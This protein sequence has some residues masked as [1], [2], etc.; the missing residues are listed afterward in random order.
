M[1][2]AAK[3]TFIVDKITVKGREFYFDGN[4]KITAANGDFENPKPNAFSTW[5]A[6][7]CPWR[8]PTCEVDQRVAACCIESAS[9]IRPAKKGRAVVDFDDSA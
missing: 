8:T 9:A 7:D 6:I 1:T 5:Q 2:T 4:Q 3:T